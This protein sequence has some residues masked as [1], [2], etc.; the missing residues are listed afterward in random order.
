MPLLC[1]F[2]VSYPWVYGMR[3]AGLE[4]DLRAGVL[5]VAG[6]VVTVCGQPLGSVITHKPR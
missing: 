4:P 2:D 3:T 6:S 1:E 5:V